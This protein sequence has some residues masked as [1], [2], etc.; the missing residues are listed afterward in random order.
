MRWN[1]LAQIITHYSDFVRENS[2][3]PRNDF[4]EDYT[5]SPIEDPIGGEEGITF[6]DEYDIDQD[7]D[8]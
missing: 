6:Y 8:K 1:V 5:E 3:N 4:H 7:W 2:D